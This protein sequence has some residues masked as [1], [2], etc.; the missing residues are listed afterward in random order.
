MLIGHTSL[1][2]NYINNK[3]IVPKFHDETI[4]NEW[5]SQNSYLC[6]TIDWS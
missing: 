4:L 1:L 3:H 6:E 5:Y 2:N